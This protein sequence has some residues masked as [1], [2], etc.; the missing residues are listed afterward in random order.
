[1]TLS[2]RDDGRGSSTPVALS[3][4]LPHQQPPLPGVG[5]S[6]D[7]YPTALRNQL[8]FSQAES[9]EEQVIQTAVS[10]SGDFFRTSDENCNSWLK[11]AD[12]KD[13]NHQLL[14]DWRDFLPNRLVST[15]MSYALV[16]LKCNPLD[17]S[18]HHLSEVPDLSD[19]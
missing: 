18:I 19:F 10:R 13:A 3:G 16:H 2:S 1:M 12:G 6:D 14:A 5:Y 7:A 9:P 15:R 17:P 11:I 4:R 8:N